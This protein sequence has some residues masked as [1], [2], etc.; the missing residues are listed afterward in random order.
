M[1]VSLRVRPLTLKEIEAG[2][3]SLI[4]HV[5]LVRT[6]SGVIVATVARD[7][8]SDRDGNRFYADC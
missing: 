8:V 6:D 1:G 5:A 7:D 4:N 2:G 3:A